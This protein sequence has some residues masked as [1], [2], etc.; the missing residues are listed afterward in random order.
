M[1]ENDTT[2]V[3]ELV[4]IR[5]EAKHE[6]F[7]VNPRIAV[8]ASLLIE[9]N[10]PAYENKFNNYSI[11]VKQETHLLLERVPAFSEPDWR[12]G[13][14]LWFAKRTEPERPAESP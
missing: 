13:W 5:E 12:P 7:E 11:Y 2:F 4:V 14:S 6:S 9:L 10:I 3:V 8:V 1:W